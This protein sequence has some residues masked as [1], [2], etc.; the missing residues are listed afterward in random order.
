MQQATANLILR[1]VVLSGAV[2]LGILVI[3]TIGEYGIALLIAGGIVGCACG[4]K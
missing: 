3:A 1:L 2:A 4:G